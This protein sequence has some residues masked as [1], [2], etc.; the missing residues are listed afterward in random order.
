MQRNTV[1]IQNGET[2]FAH[3]IGTGPFMFGSFTLGERSH[4]AR[5]PNYWE[6]GKP[7]VDAWEDISIDDDAHA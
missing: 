7:Y 2:D 5:N 4:C 1:I 3:P 6:Q